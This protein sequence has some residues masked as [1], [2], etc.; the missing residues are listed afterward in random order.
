MIGNSYACTWITALVLQVLFQSDREA[1][2]KL[3]EPRLMLQ[4]VRAPNEDVSSMPLAIVGMLG[5][6][7]AGIGLSLM[8]DN[9]LLRSRACSSAVSGSGNLEMDIGKVFPQLTL[10]RDLFG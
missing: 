8:I 3:F 1:G 7:A 9:S 6:P 10:S 4:I 5:V 2:C